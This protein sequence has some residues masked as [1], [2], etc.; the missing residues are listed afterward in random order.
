[1]ELNAKY[2]RINSYEKSKEKYLRVSLFVLSVAL[3]FALSIYGHELWGGI[4]GLTLLTFT[5]L[6]ISKLDIMHPNTWFVP[7]FYLYSVSVPLLVAIGDMAYVS[8][9]RETMFIE[10]VA[11]LTFIVVMGQP[12][13]NNKKINTK[14]L[15]NIGHVLYPIYLA[16]F[17]LTAISV[18]YVY[19]S[20][21]TSKYAISLDN[22]I[23]SSFSA[24]FSIYVL[25][26]V[27]ILARNLIVKEK[28]PKAFIFFNLAYATLVVVI[29]G[30]RDIVLRVAIASIFLVHILYK[31]LKK[32]TIVIIGSLLLMSIPLMF[33]VKNL[34][35]SDR[36][37]LET[38][39]GFMS[40]LL[41]SEFNAASRNLQ[42]VVENKGLWDYFYGQTYVWDFMRAFFNGTQS[43][44]LWFHEKFFPDMIARGAG[45]GFTIVGEGYINFGIF[46]V[47]ML[48]AVIAMFIKFLY[49]KSQKN[50]I[51]LAVYI[52]TL[53]I[54]VY[55]IRADFTTLLAQVSKHI[56]LPI[57]IIFIVKEIVN[58]AAKVRW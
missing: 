56:I 19:F 21:L 12:K 13:K 44:T 47:V 52:L 55:M 48:F 34:F 28:I 57:V 37:V 51:W 41:S 54:M 23:F 7:I 49:K 32:R 29:L 20:G 5:S 43:A 31:P 33:R 4:L 18:I 2:S 38:D 9:L 46:G 14:P 17:G 39:M 22:S 53:P 10:M 27:F 11:M 25:A 24:F 40:Q 35:V 15:F 6:S 1:M 50:V 36:G 30:E 26:F 45:N 8:H 58:K 42:I 3:S 16:A